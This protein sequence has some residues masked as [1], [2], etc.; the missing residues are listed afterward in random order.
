MADFCDVVIEDDRWDGVLDRLAPVAVSATLRFLDMQAE[1]VVMG[2]D[3]GRIAELNGDFRDKPRPTNVLSWPAVDPAPR[4]PGAR[5]VVDLDPDDPVL[6]DV[7]IAFDTCAREATE[8]GKPLADHVT[9]LLVHG[10]LHLAGYDHL[11]DP[12]AEHMEQAEREILAGLGI[13]DPYQEDMT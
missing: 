3:D 4:T 2:C 8:Q 1:V 6:G 12:D 9:H 7:A 5:P 10:V 13:N 11:N